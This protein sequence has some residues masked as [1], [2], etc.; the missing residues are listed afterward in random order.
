M[1]VCMYIHSPTYPS[2]G[3]GGSGGKL[4]GAACREKAA[5]QGGKAMRPQSCGFL[6]TAQV[7][8]CTATVGVA[9]TRPLRGTSAHRDVLCEL[10]IFPSLVEME[11][12][13]CSAS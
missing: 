3:V 9:A 1:Y 2:H 13:L 5:M 8:K 6:G 11:T 10:S 12:Q 7:S 4:P